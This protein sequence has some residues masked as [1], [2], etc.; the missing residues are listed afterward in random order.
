MQEKLLPGS[1]A[2]IQTQTIERLKDWDCEFR[3]LQEAGTVLH[4]ARS[5]RLIIKTTSSPPREGSIL[6]DEKGRRACKVLEI[7]GPVSSPYLSAQPLTDR[8]ERVTG[9]K[10]FVEEGTF[11]ENPRRFSGNKFGSRSRNRKGFR[12]NSERQELDWKMFPAKKQA[13]IAGLNE[14]PICRGNLVGD[15]E[16]GEI[17]CPQLRL[18]R[19]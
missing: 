5:G 16:K 4:L 6:V 14:C 2:K 7:I 12:G 15:I 18:C 19:S 3:P 1:D 17:L 11:G 10:L 9:T 8:I 13:G